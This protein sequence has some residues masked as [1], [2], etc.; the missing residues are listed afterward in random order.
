MHTWAA[1]GKQALYSPPGRRGIGFALTFG[2]VT[3]ISLATLGHGCNFGAPFVWR[4][5]GCRLSGCAPS[6][7][8][9]AADGPHHSF[10][11][12]DAGAIRGVCKMPLGNRGL[13][14]T[15]LMRSHMREK[16]RRKY[17]LPPACGLP[18]GVDDC[19]VLF[20]C[21]YCASHQMLR[22]LELR[23]V[24]APGMGRVC[25]SG[26]GSLCLCA[27]FGRPK[28]HGGFN[29]W[30]LTNKA[31]AAPDK[32]PTSNGGPVGTVGL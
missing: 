6:V 30:A 26:V 28:S 27:P 32:E 17:N 5:C 13:R 19:V 9:T 24:Q 10:H 25:L 12:S 2:L 21:S 4:V 18:P 31:A 16:L 8:T 22:E 23:G 14:L 11:S 3:V 15:T 7:H 1:D 20:F 29:A